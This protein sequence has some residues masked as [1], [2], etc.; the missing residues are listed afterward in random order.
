[1]QT[2]CIFA[3]Y[4]NIYFILFIVYR[5]EISVNDDEKKRNRINADVNSIID[6]NRNS[7]QILLSRQPVGNNIENG[8]QYEDHLELFSNSQD[9]EEQ[10]TDRILVTSFSSS[11]N[12]ER[13]HLHNRDNTPIQTGNKYDSVHRTVGSDN[14]IDNKYAPVNPYESTY[15]QRQKSEERY[16]TTEPNKNYPIHHVSFQ[17]QNSYERHDFH[18]QE[19][20][21]EVLQNNPT[22]GVPDI[23]NMG[24][25][26][27][28]LG[29]QKDVSDQT[30]DSYEVYRAQVYGSSNGAH[31]KSDHPRTAA[32]NSPIRD[33]SFNHKIGDSNLGEM[34]LGKHLIKF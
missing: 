22:A 11:E 4:K 13:E 2:N 34:Q 25:Y 9:L 12:W 19:H 1:M 15:D 28:K 23:Y 14:F 21:E 27:P 24:S 18:S 7:Q 8:I 32:N 10:S 6:D 33:M 5:L 31:G 29:D 16:P 30:K 3:V 20:Q 26:S 17:Q